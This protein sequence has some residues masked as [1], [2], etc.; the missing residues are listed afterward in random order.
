VRLLL[1]EG[2]APLRAIQRFIGDDGDQAV[3][4]MGIISAAHPAKPQ[5]CGLLMTVPAPILAVFCSPGYRL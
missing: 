4:E 2:S 5:V 3:Y 1:L